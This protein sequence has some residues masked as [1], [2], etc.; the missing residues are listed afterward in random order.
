MCLILCLMV[1]RLMVTHLPTQF[2]LLL[3]KDSKEYVIDVAYQDTVLSIAPR[4]K[5]IRMVVTKF[6]ALPIGVMMETETVV[7][8]E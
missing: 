5:V 8:I 1:T 7:L 4:D 2:A 3:K 6:V